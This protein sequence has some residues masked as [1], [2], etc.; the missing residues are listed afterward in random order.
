MEFGK[1]HDI[2]LL[3]EMT[4]KLPQ[5]QLQ[6]R[7]YQNSS[8]FLGGAEWAS[9]KFRGSLYPQ[10]LG[11]KDFLNSY[12]QQ[13]DCVELNSTYYSIPSTET[14]RNWAH[15]V[16]TV[17]PRFKFCPKIPKA[18]SHQGQLD[19]HFDLLPRFTDTIRLFEQHLGVCFLQLSE[20]V[21]IRN[22]DR[23]LG[24]IEMWPADLR[25]AIEVRHPSWFQNKKI[26]QTLHLKLIERKMS[27]VITDVV[28]NQNVLHSYICPEHLLIRFVGN[29]RHPKDSERINNW[30]RELKSLSR[31]APKEIYFFLHEEEWSVRPVAENFGNSLKETFNFT[32][33]REMPSGHQ[34]QLCLF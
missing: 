31:N 30:I 28:G 24:F 8:F 18:I 4:F 20:N 5:L 11:K 32:I 26:I 1:I 10:Q 9:D 34:D 23:L 25:L 17:N 6:N 21:S 12:A 22:L 3:D 29:V 7:G 2:E 16:H 33:P 27:W 13:F 19:S 15:D 14:I